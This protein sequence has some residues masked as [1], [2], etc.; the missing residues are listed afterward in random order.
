MAA[1]LTAAMAAAGSSSIG[2]ALV[3]IL[4]AYGISRLINKGAN[5]ASQAP[6]DTGVRLQVAPDTTNPIPLLYGSAY[7]GGKITDAQLVDQNKTMW[8]CLTLSEVPATTLL[9]SGAAVKTTIDA[10]YLDNQLVNF[11]SDGITVDYIVNEQEGTVNTS[12]RDLVQIYLYENGSFTPT[13]PSNFISNG[14]PISPAVLPPDARTLFPDWVNDHRM[15]NLTFA[16]VKI[17]YNRDK[18]VTGLPQLQFKVSNNLYRPG[19]AI[20]AY[21]RNTISGAG[22]TID[23]IDT[24]SLIALNNYAD[25]TVSFVDETD[26]TT[27]TLGNRY[28]INGLINPQDNVLANLQKL[29]ANA[30]SFL[31]YDIATGKWG[32]V[33]NR[34]ASPVLHFNDSNIISGIDLT[35]TNLDNLYNSVTV[36]FPH[37]ELRDQMDTI[38]IDLP[39]EYRNANEPDNVLQ[40]KLDLLNEPLQARE[41]AYLELYQ[42]RM[43]QIV[44]FTTDYSKINTEAGDVI[45]I[46]SSVY[47]WTNKPYRVIRVREIEGDDG[48]L[49]VEITAQEYDS[50]MYTAGGQPRRPRVP[51]KPIDIPDIGIIGTPAAPTVVQ[52]NKIAVPALDLTGIVPSGIVDRFEFWGSSTAGYA[53]STFVLLGSMS[54]SNGSPYNQGDQLTFR[55]ANVPAGTFKFKVRAGNEKAFGNFSPLSAEVVWDPIQVSD[56]VNPD[57]QVSSGTDLLPM[58]AMGAVA[59]FAYKALYP[60]VV[61]ALNN[62]ELG[63]LLGVTPAEAEGIKTDLNTQSDVFKEVKVAGGGGSSG[64]AIAASDWTIL[65]GIS[66]TLTFIPG[67]GIELT[68]DQIAGEITIN[69]TGQTTAGVNKVIAG[70]GITVTPSEGTGDVTISLTGGTG[71]G[72]GPV[73]SGASTSG[74]STVLN[75]SVFPCTYDVNNQDKPAIFT[76]GNIVLSNSA[77]GD[78]IPTA[79]VVAPETILTPYLTVNNDTVPAEPPSNQYDT[80]QFTGGPSTASTDTAAEA[81]ARAEAVAKA[82]A[83]YSN[84]WTETSFNEVKIKL[85]DNG[86]YTANYILRVRYPVTTT[87]STDTRTDNYYYYSKCIYN[88][89][90]GLHEQAWDDWKMWKEPTTITTQYISGYTNPPVSSN[91]GYIVDGEYTPGGVGEKAPGA[92]SYNYNPFL[93]NL[94]IYQ[95]KTTYVNYQTVQC[96]PGELVTFGVC[97]RNLGEVVPFA[98]NTIFGLETKDAVKRKSQVNGYPGSEMVF[99]NGKYVTSHLT[100]NDS[101]FWSTDTVNWTAVSDVTFA[102][103]ATTDTIN[104]AKF[105]LAPYNPISGRF[106]AWRN[107]GVSTLNPEGNSHILAYST[108]GIKWTETNT[109]IGSGIVEKINM[110]PAGHYIANTYT[111]SM[112]GIKTQTAS[113]YSTDGG[114]SWNNMA[115]MV[116]DS[117][118]WDS[119]NNRWIDEESYFASVTATFK[120]SFTVQSGVQTLSTY[121]NNYSFTKP[122]NVPSH[123]VFGGIQDYNINTKVRS[124]KQYVY[125]NNKIYLLY[126]NFTIVWMSPGYDLGR[127][128][129]RGTGISY[130]SSTLTFIGMYTISGNAITA[131]AYNNTSVLTGLVGYDS[132]KNWVWGLAGTSPTIIYANGSNV[133]WSNNGAQSANWFSMANNQYFQGNN[134]YTLMTVTPTST[135]G[136]GPIATYNTISAVTKYFAL[137]VAYATEYH[138]PGVSGTPTIYRA[139]DYGVGAYSNSVSLTANY[140]T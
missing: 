56:Q 118:A 77:Y 72:T 42:N 63:K 47:N 119:N 88:P 109:S 66:P 23:N 34:D 6:A 75:G 21:M 125:G 94:P 116:S 41:L 10:V 2:G 105:K 91:I 107:V 48:G 20:N 126:R 131:A 104:V 85:N 130:E 135:P 40:L 33:I 132:A 19:D 62:T 136:T 54:N 89:A 9:S 81:A 26:G 51:S 114:V 13:L 25:D 74:N 3:R 101:L 121:L 52:R 22:L 120:T 43:D 124:V 57:T 70:D 68:A 38:T 134:Q 137:P 5:D 138:Y 86:T 44:T 17:T 64:A 39:D 29:A 84:T 7:F 60:E 37:R 108:D 103:N 78:K 111:V 16:L 76:H 35:G 59:Y 45:T 18:G 83:L 67:T 12:H 140:S 36:E 99:G 128:D 24:D 8:Y 82:N 122:S 65:P 113:R 92:D 32:V 95:S 96:Q 90:L 106:Y 79:N 1:F 69:A 71:G 4:I 129:P 112:A 117:V 53:D 97:N 11:K 31:N 133:T 87:P 61:K 46:T 14:S 100:K 15:V 115:F 49:A 102:G 80:D 123:Y 27:K 98:T 127:I 28:Q 139:G 50:T 55:A 110:N 73:D 30:G 58:L 93:P